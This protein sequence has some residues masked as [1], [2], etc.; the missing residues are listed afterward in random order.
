MRN[1]YSFSIYYQATSRRIEGTSAERKVH[2]LFFQ[3]SLGKSDLT[4]AQIKE[5]AAKGRLSNYNHLLCWPFIYEL[6]YITISRY[7]RYYTLVAVTKNDFE[8][9]KL[10]TKRIDEINTALKM[11]TGKEME[12]TVKLLQFQNPLTISPDANVTMLAEVEELI[13]HIDDKFALIEAMLLDTKD[14]E[15]TYQDIAF[16]RHVFNAHAEIEDLKVFLE[17]LKHVIPPS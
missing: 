5:L 7:G 2:H 1:G 15:I 17:E 6:G 4:L 8:K 12:V 14:R 11:L 10:R 9:Y 13:G 3:K 16:L